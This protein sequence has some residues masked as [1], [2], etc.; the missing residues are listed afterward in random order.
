MQ[1][2]HNDN[3]REKKEA[4]THTMGKKQH[5]N[6]QT[7]NNNKRKKNNKKNTPKKKRVERNCDV[8]LNPANMG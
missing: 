6:K 1:T 5:T 3:E 8:V 7:K 2:L 4:N